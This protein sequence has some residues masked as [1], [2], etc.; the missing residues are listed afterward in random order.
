MVAGRS[1]GGKDRAASARRGAAQ[2]DQNRRHSRSVDPFFSFTPTR[3]AP[4]TLCGW[5]WVLHAGP[6]SNKVDVLVKL[7]ES[8]VDVFR[9]NMSHGKQEEHAQTA[10]NVREAAA[11]IGRTGQLHVLRVAVPYVR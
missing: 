7:I 4:L 11:K 3:G 10:A 8:G 1:G 6:A 9:L 2:K 5:V